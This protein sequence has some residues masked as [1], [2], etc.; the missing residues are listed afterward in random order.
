MSEASRLGTRTAV[1]VG[2]TVSLLAVRGALALFDV[3]DPAPGT[4]AYLVVGAVVTGAVA[5]WARAARGLVAPTAVPTVAFLG[6]ALATWLRYVAP[7]T[8]PSPVGPT[9]LGWL[10]LGWPAVV[11]LG[12]AGGVVELYANRPDDA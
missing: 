1:G 12:L 3:T 4:A 8:T 7:A 6:A 5:G 10:L 9:P 11:L 2:A